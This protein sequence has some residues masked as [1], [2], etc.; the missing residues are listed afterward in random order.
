MR[1]ANPVLRP[2]LRA[3]APVARAP[4]A[5]GVTI[6]T[7]LFNDHNMVRGWIRK[8]LDNP[9]LAPSL[10]PRIS[11]ALKRHSKAEEQT[12]YNAL[13]KYPVMRE[14]ITAMAR[15]HAALAGMLKRLDATAYNHP[16]WMG[17]FMAARRALANHL[18][19]EEDRVFP[20]AKTLLPIGQQRM[21][22]VR[23]RALMDGLKRRGPP[24]RAAAAPRL[25][26]RAI[27]RPRGLL[28]S[29]LD[30]LFPVNR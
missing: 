21:L 15:E 7:A 28:D 3:R 12:F 14:Q 29:A 22:A 24:G 23:Y 10:Y 17:R 27:R 18:L 25:T 30:M 11:D 1:R 6:T 16:V 8:L 5:G 20:E 19:F 9:A 4:V 13:V 26:A 2:A